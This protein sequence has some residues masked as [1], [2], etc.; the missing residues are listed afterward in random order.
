MRQNIPIEGNYDSV[1][2]LKGDMKVFRYFSTKKDN[3]RGVKNVFSVS[4]K[5]RDL[6]VDSRIKMMWRTCLVK[7]YRSIFYCFKCLGTGHK[8]TGCDKEVVCG[9]CGGNHDKA[10]CTSKEVKCAVCDKKRIPGVSLKHEAYSK[11][12]ASLKKLLEFEAK[13]TNYNA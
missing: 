1:D 2:K 3:E 10:K 11:E 5:L 4:G 8:A 6:I 13:R 12:C 7:D 9:K